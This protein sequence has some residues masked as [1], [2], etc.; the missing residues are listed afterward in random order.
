M[1]NSILRL[2]SSIF[3]LP[4]PLAS[5]PAPASGIRPG[6]RTARARR[7]SGVLSRC[8]AIC[9]LLLPFASGAG[10]Q[11]AQFSF[12][13][14]T[15]TGDISAFGIAIDASGN[16]YI[17]AG[18]S[19]LKETLQTDG[20]YVESTV[21]GGLTDAMSVAVDKHGNVFIADFEGHKVLEETLQADGSYSQSTIATEVGVGF[22]GPI[23]IAVD[24]YEQVYL[25]QE[26]ASSGIVYI[27]N[28][29]GPG[30][31]LCN[32]KIGS[33]FSEPTAIAV[34]STGANVY[35][36]D[37]ASEEQKIHLIGDT[38][39]TISDSLSQWQG[40][41]V[42]ASGNLYVVGLY[43]SIPE[44]DV[45]TLQTNGSYTHTLLELS[46]VTNPYGV[47]VD[48]SGN[49]FV[50]NQNN[51]VVKL[52][53]SSANF[54]SV[55]VGDTASTIS[56]FFTF[57]SA[58]QLGGPYVLTQGAAGLDFQ[59]AGTGT[60]ANNTVYQ[61]GDSCWIDVSFKP[62]LAGPRYGSAVL[63]N[64]SGD[65]I[66]TGYLQG[67]GVAPRVSFL[68][69]GQ[70]PV[71]SGL[72]MPNGIAADNS[73]D[74]YISNLNN[75]T[76]VKETLSSGSYSQTKVAT[77]TSLSSPYGVAVDGSGN[78]YI[79]DTN[80]NRV[81]LENISP[82]GS[83]KEN[84]IGSGLSYPQ[85]VAVDGAGNVYIADTGNNRVLKET[86]ANGS[87]TQ[88][89]VVSSL[90]NPLAVA[91]DSYGNLFIARG[92]SGSA[93]TPVYKETLQPDGSYV[94]SAIGSGFSWPVGIAVDAN[95]NVYVADNT[96]L[97]VY[98][99]TLQ[100]DG[101]YTQSTLSLTG[102]TLPFGVAVDGYG[103]VYAT[104]ASIN[105]DV[106]KLDYSAAPSLSFDSTVIGEI[107]ADSP[108]TVIV[109]NSGNA[110]LSFSG[111]SFPTGF[112]ES[113]METTDCTTT[114]SL[115]ANE[116]CTLTID[117]SPQVVGSP[118]GSLQ[119]TD[120]ALNAATAKQSISLSGT[121][122]D[123]ASYFT[124]TGPTPVTAGTSTSITVKVYDALGNLFAGYTGTVHF[125]S[126]DSSAKLPAN[127]TLTGATG[128]FNVTF[129]TAGTQTV[130]ATDTITSS[131]TGTS[132]SIAVDQAPAIT[133]ANNTTFTVG[134]AGSF[135]VTASGN[136]AS[137]F[138]ES[139]TLPSGVTL[140]TAGL[141]SGTPAAGTGGSYPITIT[142]ANGTTNATQNFTLTV[143]Q[144]PAITSANNTTFTVGTAG[145]FTVTAS[146]N[147]ASTFTESG[148]LPSG[149]TLTTAGL[150]SGTPAGGT[151]GIYPITITANNGV[152]PNATQSFTL[153]ISQTTAT[154]TVTL[155]NLLQTYSGAPLS[156]TAT[157]S[158]VSGLTVTFTYTGISPTTYPTSSAP[159][160]GA[161]SYTVVGT[162]SNP[163]Y[164][165]SAT[166]TLVISPATETVSLGNLAQT[167]TGSSLAATAT[168]SPVSGLTVTFTYTGISP[169]TYATSSTPPTAAGSYTVV[170]TVSNPNYQGSATGTLVISVSSGGTVVLITTATLT[171]SASTGYTATVTVANTGTGTASNVLLTT[172][173]LGSAT[174]SPLPQ[175]L[176]SIASGRADTVTVQFPGSAG[177]DGARVAED[178]AG[179][180]T[181]GTFSAVIRAVLP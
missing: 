138:T 40:I 43:N 3:V 72:S 129:K 177:S 93:L 24:P 2:I 54:G 123:K 180:S 91:V 133:S 23:G 63:T 95:E 89:P 68:P 45:Q 116:S 127:S 42:D 22:D 152:S 19:V 115:P 5:Q 158:P 167:Y 70:S 118:G 60:C 74:L 117:F 137:T 175:T 114:A 31:S 12:T 100:P 6:T 80:H 57:N 109:E 15:V 69:G 135:T 30:Y 73:G 33:G 49:I 97:Q 85:G 9:L 59:N 134:T 144:A 140:T 20:S 99:E 145:S 164:Q 28:S 119:L 32:C 156:A 178:Y 81:L 104:D 67:M 98:E 143:D 18:T 52:S 125:T 82:T 147:P 173:T 66:A 179:T 154:A 120:N 38:Q 148:T 166:G 107:S 103:S 17:A 108:K 132:N 58:V 142:A 13:Q 86:L 124:V 92:G 130:T 105:N 169:T 27:P 136:P 36:V 56:V 78:V 1:K 157:T 101:S 87:Y 65:V 44:L 51:Q 47:A 71:V 162:V 126:T 29:S 50:S 26:G 139:G 75:N 48:T 84:T 150:L 181:G 37:S 131:I 113:G 14:S 141:L 172:A 7:W 121:G 112:P 55:S 111:I 25:V 102:L 174:G 46:G 64:S 39:T 168:T 155:G 10:A 153:T 96:N 160:T 16:L 79:A 163:N 62:S 110:A 106:V 61:A 35:I 8:A 88:S 165:G 151:G 128:T 76:V 171:G 176:G 83:S 159:P 34:D 90:D 146:G 94:Q 4:L 161:G 41:A 11:T 122:T 53:R 170:G 21:T 77:A 149:V